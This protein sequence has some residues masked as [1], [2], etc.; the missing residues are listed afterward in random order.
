VI[1]ARRPEDPPGQPQPECVHEL[2]IAE[3]LSRIASASGDGS[4]HG[5]GCT[6]IDTQT[7]AG[8]RGTAAP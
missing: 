4:G 3:Q 7:V 5:H 1:N 8:T 6:D 2:L